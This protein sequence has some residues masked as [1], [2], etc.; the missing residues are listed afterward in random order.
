M[1]ILI[2]GRI[3]DHPCLTALYQGRVGD[4]QDVVVIH[5]AQ[6]PAHA[7]IRPYALQIVQLIQRVRRDVIEAVVLGAVYADPVKERLI[8]V[9]DIHDAVAK[10]AV[11]GICPQRMIGDVFDR[12]DQRPVDLAVLIGVLIELV[13]LLEHVFVEVILAEQLFSVLVIRSRFGRRDRSVGVG[14]PLLWAPN[15]DVAVL[16]AVFVQLFAFCIND[17]QHLEVD[18]LRHVFPKGRVLVCHDNI[19]DVEAV[20]DPGF[21]GY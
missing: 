12:L 15:D 9:L 1:R 10:F 13:V 17:L 5:I 20:L 16:S 7:D 11:G 14:Q 6:Q 2:F 4:G 18:D 19:K 21:P 8:T 3:I